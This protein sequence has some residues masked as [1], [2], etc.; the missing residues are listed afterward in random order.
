MSKVRQESAF[1]H[2]CGLPC[3]QCRSGACPTV[4]I[5]TSINAF[6]MIWVDGPQDART[7]AVI[8]LSPFP[9]WCFRLNLPG[10]QGISLN[11]TPSGVPG[12][13]QAAQCPIVLMAFSSMPVPRSAILEM[14]IKLIEDCVQRPRSAS[15]CRRPQCV[16][17]AAGWKVLAAIKGGWLGSPRQGVEDAGSSWLPG[18]TRHQKNGKQS[19]PKYPQKFQNAFFVF[20]R[21]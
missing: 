3:D 17:W 19:P 6:L 5:K 13:A 11:K 9:L 7:A 14:A 2:Y 18:W 12:A 16:P 1:F 15:L 21:L 8:P 20:L 4:E 10:W